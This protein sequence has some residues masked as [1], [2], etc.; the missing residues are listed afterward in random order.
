MVTALRSHEAYAQ[1]L[2]PCA[3]GGET[4][5]AYIERYKQCL[6]AALVERG[7]EG[8]AVL[9]RVIQDLLETFVAE[10][11]TGKWTAADWEERP[12]MKA[13][14]DSF[15]GNDR[16]KEIRRLLMVDGEDIDR[17]TN[18]PI[19]LAALMHVV[20]VDI[21]EAAP[22]I[23]LWRARLYFVYQRVL[24][25]RSFTLLQRI[26]KCYDALLALATPAEE[27]AAP[28]APRPLPNGIPSASELH[29][30]KGLVHYYFHEPHLSHEHILQAV[31][32]SGMKHK[33]TSMLGVR[34]EHQLF[35]TAQ[36]VVRV[37]TNDPEAVAAEAAAPVEFLPTI[38]EGSNVLARPRTLEENIAAGTVDRD[39]IQTKEGERPEDDAEVVDTPLTAYE[40]AMVL[41]LCTNV[42]NNN[43]MHG[44]TEAERLPYLERMFLEERTTYLLKSVTLLLRSRMEQKRV[45]V[46][47][48]GLLQFCD[49]CDQFNHHIKNDDGAVIEKSTLHRMESFW[50]ALYPPVFSLQT[51]LAK[52]YYEMGMLKSSLDIHESLSN[53]HHVIK[54]CKRLDKRNKAEVLI[55]SLLS[56]DPDDAS[57]WSFLG[58]ATREEAHYKKA[59]ELSGE[60]LAQSMRGLGELYLEKERFAEAV[61][62][63]DKALQ[64]NPVYGANWFSMGWAAVKTGQWERASQCY[65][66]NVQLDN[67][68]GMSWSNLATCYLQMGGKSVQAFHCL[69]QARKYSPQKDWRIMDNLFTVAVEVGERVTAINTL[70]SLLELKGRDYRV[71]GDVLAEL[72]RIVIPVLQGER[73]AID[74]D[75][76]KKHAH[77]DPN[78]EE[79]DE[80]G[81]ED[82]IFNIVPFGADEDLD[83]GE[84]DDA[85]AEEKAMEEKKQAAQALADQADLRARDSLK[86]SMHR[87]LGKVVSHC[88]SD[89]SLYQSYG[90]FLHAIDNELEAF[91]QYLK[92]LR[93][94][95]KKN[96]QV[97]K[98]TALPAVK[99][100]TQVAASALAVTE[101]HLEARKVKTMPPKMQAKMQVQPV[102]KL[103][104]DV[105]GTTEEYQALKTKVEQLE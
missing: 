93:C 71:R 83:M 73:L 60:K 77:Y 47:E 72:V 5:K 54:C 57:L 75:I 3:E 49:M 48:R 88:T 70:G 92:A 35:E 21:E 8:N 82:E 13:M 97:D 26:T 94:L 43:P 19:L 90:A 22:V 104:E 99:C 63:F 68:D 18:H 56:D 95:T 66:R 42:R 28:P 25:H 80:D 24:T 89:A 14:V 51:E 98:K 76:R 84:A 45:R 39:R 81:W 38:S 53:W 102:V 36:L 29:L 103:A 46:R 61:E 55:K 105:W 4:V 50:V 27:P 2:P 58:D 33:L 67:T 40:Q 86:T 44:L 52:V 87:L 62:C 64:L 15:A 31:K 101:S 10:N 30:A 12:G 9:L 6:S 69:V 41:A 78:A 23:N 16:V 11:F 17:N 37:A 91:D 74:A 96:W 85:A 20:E 32:L 65:T 100:A 7:D 1:L 79:V 34:T 59:W